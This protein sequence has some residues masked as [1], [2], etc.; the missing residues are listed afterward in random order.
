MTTVLPNEILE[1]VFAHVFRKLYLDMFKTLILVNK[2]F[3]R[4]VLRRR[5]NLMLSQAAVLSSDHSGVDFR[6]I[7]EKGGDPFANPNVDRMCVIFNVLF[8][9]WNDRGL[10][11]LAKSMY[12]YR[13]YIYAKM[14]NIDEPTIFSSSRDCYSATQFIR[15]GEVYLFANVRFLNIETEEYGRYDLVA[16]VYDKGVMTLRVNDTGDDFRMELRRSNNVLVDLDC[17]LYNGPDR[18]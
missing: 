5:Q 15:R 3:N 12:K 18:S 1:S 10:F 6:I 13:Q 8:S 16:A 17:R 14:K 9:N 4:L 2:H 11:F 7:C